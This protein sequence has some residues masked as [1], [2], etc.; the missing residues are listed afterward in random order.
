MEG[1]QLRVVLTH[2][3]R[4]VIQTSLGKR[5][6]GGRCRAARSV[7]SPNTTRRKLGIDRTCC[8]S[9]IACSSSL[10]RL[11]LKC[12][13][14]VPQARQTP[15]FFFFFFT[16]DIFFWHFV[17]RFFVQR[18][19]SWQAKQSRAVLFFFNVLLCVWLVMLNVSP[20]GH[21]T[22]LTCQTTSLPVTSLQLRRWNE[23]GKWRRDVKHDVMFSSPSARCG[24]QRAARAATDQ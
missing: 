10:P 8:L 19:A 9:E 4:R 20:G 6:R 2:F 7:N 17:C 11:V 5:G 16:I 15:T 24:G 12:D 1:A 3:V 21:A 23:E 14:V 18:H 13:N 22:T